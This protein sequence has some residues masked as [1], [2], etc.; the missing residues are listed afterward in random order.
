MC[1]IFGFIVTPDAGLAPEDIR[2]IL[3]DF[4]RLSEKRGREAAGLALMHE[5][6]IDVFKRPGQAHEMMRTP[7]YKA[8]VDDFLKRVSELSPTEEVPFVAMG[9]SR[10]VTNGAESMA[11]NNQ[12]VV[13]EQSVGIHNGIVVNAPALWDENPDLTREAE[14]DSEIIFRLIDKLCVDGVDLPDAAARAFSQIEG[15]ANI[16]VMSDWS[17]GLLLATNTGSLYSISEP[18]RGIFLFASEHF[19]LDEILRRPA[20]RSWLKADNIVHTAAG[21][22]FI[23]DET[24]D[25]TVQFDL[26]QAANEPAPEPV[27]TKT[28]PFHRTVSSRMA[29]M[30]SLRRCTRCVLPST[31]PF[32]TFDHAGVCSVC[33][34]HEKKS[35]H[36]VNALE[37]IADRHRRCD[38]TPD[39][40]VAFSGGRDSSYGLHYV[41]EH[42]GMT[43]IAFTYDWGMVTDLARRNQARICGKLGIEHIIRAPHIPSKR[44]NIRCNLDAW[45]HRPVLGMIP[46][47]MAGDKQMYQVARD[48]RKETGTEL[49][50]F[51]AGNELERTEFKT[52]FCGIR[53]NAHGQVLWK[54]SLVNKI[55]LALYYGQQFARN[56]WYINR[57]VLDSLSAFYST[58]IGTDDFAYLYHYLQWD[59]SEI[60]TTLKEHYDWETATDA[61]TTWRVGDGTVAFYNYIYYT[62]AGF[63][64]HDTFRS[65]QIRADL[66]EREEALQ[67]LEIDNRPRYE[68]MRDYASLVGFNLDEALI[69]INSIP[70]LY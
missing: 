31:F 8:F 68:S 25:I 10:L 12:P 6:T 5:D 49:V 59:E 45:L 34:D 50:L 11:K 63:S 52:G 47:L 9:H 43:P 53:E 36:G 41:S 58:Y 18:D 46:L 54:F 17:T 33:R 69:V 28:L 51:C 61:S 22:G 3:G 7:E 57:S 70:K 37:A 55:R 62:V 13:C 2:D 27:G 56:P 26:R 39:C 66:I 65:N 44:R 20:F 38:G 1:G 67:L 4:F 15:A 35:L 19:T 24:A 30:R 16:A 42:L 21:H 14:L 60:D 29:D 48:L 40:L 64:E 32:I 23:V